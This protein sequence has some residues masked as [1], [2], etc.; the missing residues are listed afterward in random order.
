MADGGKLLVGLGNPGSRYARNRHNVGFM[1]AEAIAARHNLPPWRKRFLGAFTDGRVGSERAYVLMPGTY[2]NESGNAIAQ[3]MNYFRLTPA[4]VYVFHDE[5][6]LAP[7]KIRVKL[8]GGA[9]GNNGIRSTIAHIGADFYRV[10]IGIGHPG[11]KAAVQPW[12]LGDFSKVEQ[13][14]LVPL[15]D[16]IADNAD[17]LAKGDN[18]NFMNRVALATADQDD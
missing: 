8:G 2:M 16:A 3:A 13:E 18:A 5:L 6:D 17:C 4:D 1:A 7:G 10:R 15:L 11:H 9:A 14:W 12:V